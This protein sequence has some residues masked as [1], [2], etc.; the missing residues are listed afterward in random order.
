MNINDG[1]L[2]E[3]ERKYWISEY[4]KYYADFLKYMGHEKEQIKITNSDINIISPKPTSIWIIPI[5]L[6]I[7]EFIILINLYFFS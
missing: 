3:Y 2:K 1:Y 7:L 4:Y 5:F 6:N